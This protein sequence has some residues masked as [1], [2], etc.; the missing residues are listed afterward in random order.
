MASR[1]EHYRQKAQEC[2]ALAEAGSDRNTKLQLQEAAK[3]WWELAGQE[4]F[5]ERLDVK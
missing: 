2:Q 3:Q 1:A 5:L 4:E